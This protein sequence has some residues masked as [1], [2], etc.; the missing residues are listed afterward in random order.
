VRGGVV[1][2]LAGETVT[3][4][5]R[6]LARTRPKVRPADVDLGRLGERARASWLGERS[7]ALEGRNLVA[8]VRAW[9]R[10]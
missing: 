4:E 7:A 9:T 2:R 1:R 3:G 5:T 6:S 10:Q 8:M